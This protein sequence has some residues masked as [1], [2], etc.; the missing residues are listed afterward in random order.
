[1]VARLALLSEM[2]SLIKR[3]AC[4]KVS[5]KIAMVDT[6]YFAELGPYA[7]DCSDYKTM[8]AL[9]E[10]GVDF[11]GKDKNGD[12]C[13]VAAAK[14][15]NDSTL[16]FLAESGLANIKGAKGENA[17]HHCARPRDVSTAVMLIKH[18]VSPFEKDNDGTTALDVLDRWGSLFPQDDV[19][20]CR[21][22]WMSAWE[23]VKLSAKV[24]IVSKRGL[25]K[26]EGVAL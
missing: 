12:S 23:S 5:A 3:K 24:E 8:S 16:L 22:Q 15:G 10:G 13:A 26:K 9:E 2:K 6:K 17:L 20:E 25:S 7:S 4:R 21:A 18:G 14:R 1:M 11:G 19:S